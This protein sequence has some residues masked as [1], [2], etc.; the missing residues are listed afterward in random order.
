MILNEEQLS[1]ALHGWVDKEAI[2]GYTYF[3]RFTKKQQEH[4]A[5]THFTPKERAS[6]G[7]YFETVTDA[8]ALSFLFR[9]DKASSQSFF[10]FDL[11][12]DGKMVTHIGEAAYQT[13]HEDLYTC[14]L[15]AGS[16]TLRLYFP[17]LSATGIRN[18]EL[19]N[20]TFF[21]P[22]EKK[23]KYIA[24]G[25]SITQGYT[26]FSPSLSYVNLVGDALDA[27]VYDL[28]IGGEFFQPSMV[29]EDYPVQADLVTVA[30]G[31]ND[32]G[33]ISPEEDAERRK[34]FFEKLCRAHRDAKIFV[35]LPIWRGAQDEKRNGYGTLES[36]RQLLREDAKQY[37]AIT[38]IEGENLVPHHPDFF[39]PDLLHPNALGFT[40]YAR[41]LI[42]ELKK[43]L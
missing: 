15:P 31:T 33:H 40:Q 28:G 16:K 6:A 37:P 10:F 42:C 26:T 12:I 39:M 41:N 30:Y 14:D 29:D 8:E 3:Y 7:M 36:Y 21:R 1:S 38:V 4:Y 5:A 13:P 24:Y 18:L 34:A 22:T 27:D 19:K 11:Y 32:W 20:A 2:D 43:H 17:N 35:L 23:I 25:D 9:Q